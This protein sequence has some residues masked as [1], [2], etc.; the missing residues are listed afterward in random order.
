MEN[1]KEF[2]KKWF[3]LGYNEAVK[4]YC[5]SKPNE[6]GVIDYPTDIGKRFEEW[7]INMKAMEE[8]RKELLLK[9]ERPI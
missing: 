4:H 8:N 2:A 3:K 7:Y 1:E 9:S 6:H 5:T